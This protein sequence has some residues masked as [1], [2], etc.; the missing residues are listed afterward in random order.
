MLIFNHSS[1]TVM[2]FKTDMNIIFY[3]YILFCPGEFHGL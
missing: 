2:I 3:T 1:D